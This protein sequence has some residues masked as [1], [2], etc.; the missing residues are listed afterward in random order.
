MVRPMSRLHTIERA[1]DPNNLNGP[2]DRITAVLGPTNTGKTHFA[3]ERMLGHRSGMIGLPLRLLAREVYDKI[4]ALKGT[5]EVALITGEERIVPPHPRFYVCTVEAMPVDIPVA[6]LA[7]DEIQL[8]SDPERGHIFTD[9]LINARGIEETMLLGAETMRAAIRRMA[10]S[11]H[12]L[13]RP[14]F[15]DLTYTG[16]KKLTRLPRRSA[17]VAFS[18]HEVYELADLVRAQRGGAAVILGALSPRTRNAQVEIYQS[19]DADFLIATDAIGMGINMDV[20][21]VA[22]ATLEKF[23]GAMQRPLRP[24]EIGQIAGRAGRYMNDGTFGSSADARALE[25]EVAEQVES[26]RYEP[27]RVLQ[28]RNSALVFSSVTALL[29]TLEA[30]PPTRGLTRARIASDHWTLRTLAQDDT[31]QNTVNSFSEVKLLW[32][33]CQLP[34]FHKLTADEHTKLVGQIFSFLLRDGALPDDWLARQIK[35]LDI[36]EGDVDTLSGRLAQIRTW[37]YAT[38]RPRWTTDPAHWQELTR[39][40]EDR[41]SD[42]L[43]EKLIQRFID[44]RTSL[45][46]RSLRDEKYLG[47]DVDDSGAVMIGHEY[48]GKLEGFRFSPDPRAVGIHGRTLRAAALPGLESEL[49][50]R[51]HALIDAQ[52]DD[53]HLSQHGQL[54]WRGAPVA[55][56]E[57]G[58]IPITP[59]V[60]IIADE[61]LKDPLR[62]LVATRIEHWVEHY[63]GIVLEPLVSLRRAAEAR[64]DDKQ[65]ALSGLSRGLAFQ[66]V[67]NLGQLNSPAR[68]Q[69]HE[70]SE[71]MKILGRFGVTAGRYK[72]FIPRLLKPTPCGLV[73]LLRAVHQEM[74]PV[75]APPP[76][77]L[78]SFAVDKAVSRLFIEAAY[79]SVVGDRAI[80]I[81]ILERVGREL[82][83]ASRG[84][85]PADEVTLRISSLLGCGKDEATKIAGALGWKITQGARQDDQRLI[86]CRK[87]PKPQKARKGNRRNSPPVRPDSPF[88]GLAGLI[89]RD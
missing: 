45:L 34:D 35:R 9:R 7:I 38:H 53:I 11:A 31:I 26:H 78:T 74:R 8:C 77:G 57:R 81:D 54:W 85:S 56:L 18:S 67:E 6:F 17:I 66:L 50:S 13:N 72:L 69:Q 86:W 60:Q 21:H 59:T 40:V 79:F 84:A 37:T 73:A 83:K 20:D 14:R 48:I 87:G 19:G 23:D 62:S 43:H 2:T 4:V 70:T 49:A 42:A 76:P 65:F 12:F 33:A 10:P 61:L 28:W 36:V 30:P 58:T 82:S 5:G 47:L 64:A 52:N 39:S 3:I 32:E 51:A 46:M 27:I 1:K 88:A 80:R 89:I 55:K 22:F 75:P 15:S 41:L 68:A 63:I 29:E 16:S 71:A 44:R 24:D 25:L